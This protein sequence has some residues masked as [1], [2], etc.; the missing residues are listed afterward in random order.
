MAALTGPRIRKSRAGKTGNW[1]VKATSQIWQNGLVALIA[2]KAIAARAGVDSTE[3]ATI[4][5]VGLAAN[6]VLGGAADGDQRIDTDEGVFPFA[7][8]TAGDALTLSD[9]GADVYV[10]DDQTVGKTHAT[11]TRPKAGVLKDVT[12]EGAWVKVGF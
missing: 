2:G 3:A 12:S 9:V 10:I 4:K 8:G 5:V 11:N 1:P 7:I 6:S